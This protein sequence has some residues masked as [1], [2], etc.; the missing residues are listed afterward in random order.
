MKDDLANLIGQIILHE[1]VRTSYLQ[2]L[3]SYH[4]FFHF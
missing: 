3:V 1:V 2:Y 4:D